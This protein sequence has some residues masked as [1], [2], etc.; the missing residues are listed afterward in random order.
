MPNYPRR[1]FHGVAKILLLLAV[2]TIPCR[3][4]TLQLKNNRLAAQFGPRRLLSITDLE[5]NVTLH[6]QRDEFSLLVDQESF[7]SV[8]LAAPAWSRSKTASRITTKNEDF[9]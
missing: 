1:I 8:R 6:F 2:L 7:E 4:Q 3:G 5:S 9:P